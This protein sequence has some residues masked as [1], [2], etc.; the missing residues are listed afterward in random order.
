MRTEKKRVVSVV[1]CGA[2][3][4]DAWGRRE[5]GKSKGCNAPGMNRSEVVMDMVMR[6]AGINGGCGEVA[7]GRLGRAEVLG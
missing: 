6:P 2:A 5:L 3:Q 1:W 7:S 4:N